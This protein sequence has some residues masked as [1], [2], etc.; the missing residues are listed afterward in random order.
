MPRPLTEVLVLFFLPDSPTRARWASE[1]EKAL[2]VERVRSNNQGI[3]Q[4][5]FKR[6]QVVEAARDPLTYLLFGLAFFQTLVVGG[7]NVFNSLLINQAFGFSVSAVDRLRRGRPGVRNGGP[8][9]RSWT[10][11]C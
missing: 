6:E 9:G 3:K 2:F 5:Q 11:S 8:D 4:K 10:A 7:I 1:R